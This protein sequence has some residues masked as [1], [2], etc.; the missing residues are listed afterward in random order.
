MLNVGLDGENKSF[1][2]AATKQQ[3]GYLA[4]TEA[5][6]GLEPVDAIN[7]GHRPRVDYHRG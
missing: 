2:V 7:N 5:P 6:I 4:S 3:R 1:H